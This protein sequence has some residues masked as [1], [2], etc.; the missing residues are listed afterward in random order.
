MCRRYKDHYFLCKGEQNR[1]FEAEGLFVQ[2]SSEYHTKDLEFEEID[3][4]IFLCR[5]ED[6]AHHVI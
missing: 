1:D 5:S 6:F 3:F 2:T 4:Y